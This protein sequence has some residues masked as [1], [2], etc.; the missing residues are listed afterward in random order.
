MQHNKLTTE[1][2]KSNQHIG[3][4]AGFRVQRKFKTRFP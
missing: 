3:P 1:N 2:K 4:E